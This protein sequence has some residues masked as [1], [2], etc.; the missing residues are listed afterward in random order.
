MISMATMI[1]EVY[2]AL[3]EA[4]ASEEKAR[5]AAEVLANYEHRFAKIEADLRLHSW[6]LAYLIATTTAIV[7]KVFTG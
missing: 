4:G 1:S 6:M 5:K 7:W 3:K 2:D